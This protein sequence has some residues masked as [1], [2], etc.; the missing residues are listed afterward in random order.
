MLSARLTPVLL[1]LVTVGCSAQGAPSSNAL[2][3]TPKPSTARTAAA[4]RAPSPT[5]TLPP[6]IAN[7]VD[8]NGEMLWGVASTGDTV[9]VEG[10]V[11][12][13]IDGASGEELRS[14]RGI[15]PTVVGDT[16]WYERD[17]DVIAADAQTGAERAVYHPPITGG[18]TVR[19]GI[20]WATDEAKGILARVDL[21]KEAITGRLELPDG[22]PKW[23][24]VWGDAVWVVI[25]GS[26]VVLR[27]DPRT[28]K[29]TDT[30]PA[31]SRPHSVAVGFG[32]LWVIEH[33]QS[34]VL[35]LEPK[36]GAVEAK[37]GGPGMNVAMA[38]AHDHIWASSGDSIM[39]I[40]PATNEIVDTI[41]IGAGE[42]YGM[43]YSQSSLWV[44]TGQDGNGLYQIPIQ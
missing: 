19:N 3:Q 35:R 22:E 9:W 27:I 23:V 40:D 43:A 44:T 5:P 2:A 13:Q 28:L 34:E 8:L 33:G 20:L 36:H 26:D 10:D 18:T 29:V 4:T 41:E 24:E 32:S 16:L 42:Y 6:A 30:I 12:H 39:K 37:I 25:D 1:L 14:M 7:V 11:L 31:G 17:G 15:V 21:E 38:V